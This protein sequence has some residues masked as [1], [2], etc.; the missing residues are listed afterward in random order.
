MIAAGA[1]CEASPL[2]LVHQAIPAKGGTA[3]TYR[4]RVRGYD[5]A[6]IGSTGVE[7]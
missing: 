6:I 2:S 3:C 7:Q 1:H 4:A 5:D